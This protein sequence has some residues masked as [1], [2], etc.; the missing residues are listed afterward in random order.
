MSE[1]Q[2]LVQLI[3]NRLKSGDID[4]PVFDDVALQVYRAVRKDDMDADQICELMEQDPVL[5]GE[6]LRKANSSFFSGLGAVKTL[7]DAMIRVGA[8][9]VAALALEASQKRLYSMVSGPYRKR[10]DQLW[11]HT[12]AVAYG[13]R[14]L[15]R[16][17]GYL[18]LSD[19]AFVAGLLHDVGKVSLLSIIE[20]LSKEEDGGME[21][22]EHVVDVTLKQLNASHGAALMQTWDMPESICQV[23]EQQDQ[24]EFDDSNI[25]LAIVRLVDKACAKEGFSDFPDPSLCLDTSAEAQVLNL[26]DITLAEL[27]VVLED[28][29]NDAMEKAA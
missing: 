6:A 16:K 1:K 10:L 3:D 28:A 12:S 13:S 27:Q 25:T 9:Q 4:L 29:A 7:R 23:V 26:N 2:S 18:K 15:A 21:I 22:S 5:V 11:R 14:W 19:E 24:P 8:K 20:D 17:A